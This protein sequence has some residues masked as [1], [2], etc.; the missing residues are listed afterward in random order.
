MP[1][2]DSRDCCVSSSEEIL[3]EMNTMK[4][5]SVVS[6]RDVIAVLSLYTLRVVYIAFV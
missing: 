6:P 5:S 3:E 2:F 4:H 1:G